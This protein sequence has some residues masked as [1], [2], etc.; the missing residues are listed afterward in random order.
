MLVIHSF[1]HSFNK[2]NCNTHLGSR[3]AKKKRDMVPVNAN[4]CF[5]KFKLF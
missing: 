1:I 4:F 2:Y 5:K 3:R